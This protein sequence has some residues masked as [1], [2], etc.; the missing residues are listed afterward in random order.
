[1]SH[2]DRGFALFL[3]VVLI[4]LS[5]LFFELFPRHGEQNPGGEGATAPAGTPSPP[6]VQR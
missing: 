4:A 2:A 5:T 1:M 3:M 6:A